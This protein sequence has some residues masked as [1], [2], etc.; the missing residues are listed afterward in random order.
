[1]KTF[2][3]VPAVS[4]RTAALVALAAGVALASSGCK[5]VGLGQSVGVPKA[6]LGGQSG[7]TPVNATFPTPCEVDLDFGNL[8][9]G[10]TDSVIVRI[11]NEGSTA[12]DLSQVNPTLDPAF[13]LNDGE[14]APIQAGSFSSF[15]VTFSPVEPGRC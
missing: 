7:S 3:S 6:A 1:M 8:P 14:Q 11:T 15:S 4:R 5:K 2:T 9:I 12:L 10:L 13:T